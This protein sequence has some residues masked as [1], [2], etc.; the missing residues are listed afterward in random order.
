MSGLRKAG[1]AL[2]GLLGAAL[3]VSSFYMPAKAALAQVLLER[4]WVRVQHGE[5][6]AKPWPWADMSPLA[7]IAVPRL[8]ARAI[9]LEGA[10][11]QAMAF[12]PGHMPN[13]PA[14]GA[15][16]T[17]IV[18]A[19]R[20]TQ[21]AM[22]KD[23][24]KGDLVEAETRGGRRTMFR[25]VSMRVVGA[26]ASGIDP[27]DPGPSGARLALVTCY[28]FDGVLHS[29]LRYVVLADRVR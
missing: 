11:G 25:V 10:S 3:V 22:L 24:R 6:N 21:F 8:H 29:P 18:A 26:N 2:F 15:H 7:E 13:T 20:D 23:L 9:V 12:G 19:H 17:A 1:A 16:G 4:A 28:P 14:I 27:A 5:A